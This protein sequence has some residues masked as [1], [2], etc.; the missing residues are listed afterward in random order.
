MTTQES[1]LGT[2]EWV[3]DLRDAWK[4]EAHNFTPW[5]TRNLDRLSAVLGIELELEGSEVYVGPYRADIVAIDPRD[6]SRVLIENQLEDANLQHLG[7]VLAYLAGLEAKVVVWIA[8]DF[9]EPNL[10]AIRWLNVHTDDQFAFFAIR[11]RLARI[12]DSALAPSFEVQERPNNW[13]RRVQNAA[14][15]GELSARGQFCRDFWSHVAARHPGDVKPGFAGTNCFTYVEEIGQRFTRYVSVNGVGVYLVRNR[16]ET[17][18]TALSRIEPYLEPLRNATKGEQMLDSRWGESFLKIDTRD[19]TNWDRMAD[20]LHD[21]HLV[22][23]RV[24]RE[25][26]V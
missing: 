12:G 25:T 15:H 14:Q 2:L 3:N 24:L 16:N 13:D 22:Y 18:G 4:H 17:D 10:S 26:E 11:V 5:L 7:Q 6:N 19:R 23:E 1:E 8:K 21:R 9:D 20:W